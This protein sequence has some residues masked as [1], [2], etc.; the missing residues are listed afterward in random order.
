[1]GAE[2]DDA[3]LT[4]P[5]LYPQEDI[6]CSEKCC[7]QLI[8]TYTFTTAFAEVPSSH[9]LPELISQFPPWLPSDAPRTSLKTGRHPC[10]CTP[11]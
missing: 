3:T 5:G 9:T 8:L 1:M 2:V 6:F 7:A 10:S 4:K 11:S